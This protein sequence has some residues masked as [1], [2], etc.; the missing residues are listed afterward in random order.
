MKDRFK[1]FFLLTLIVCMGSIPIKSNKEGYE[2]YLKGTWVSDLEG[3]TSLRFME[4]NLIH[5]VAKKDERNYG[6]D[7]HYR[8]EHDNKSNKHIKVALLQ[9]D[10]IKEKFIERGELNLYLKNRDTLVFHSQNYGHVVLK[11]QDKGIDFK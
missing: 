7:M 5:I 11:R 4:N 6:V 9:K 3:L 1:V 2:A 8:V 10:L